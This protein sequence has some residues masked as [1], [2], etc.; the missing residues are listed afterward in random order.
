MSRSFVFKRKLWFGKKES[1]GELEKNHRAREV[2]LNP[3][4]QRPRPFS[5]PS[6]FSF[7]LALL[8]SLERMDQ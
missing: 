7:S 1:E 5:L 3:A 2:Q 6:S 8:R 4:Q